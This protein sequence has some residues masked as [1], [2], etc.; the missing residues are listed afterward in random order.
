MAD[1]IILEPDIALYI[2]KNSLDGYYGIGNR[3]SALVWV[4]QVR[5]NLWIGMDNLHP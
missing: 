3:A 1:H 4:F 5:E 2:R